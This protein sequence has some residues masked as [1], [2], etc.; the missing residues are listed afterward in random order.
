MSNATQQRGIPTARNVDHTAFTVPDLDE[1]IDFFV[2]VLG[3]ELLYHFGPVGD[4]S[5]DFMS[6]QLNV[7]PK[8]TCR[9]AMLR[10]GPVTN[11]ELFEYD[12]PNQ[13][14]EVPRNSDWGGHHLA[15][16]VDDIE[17][18]IA[19]L[20]E[21]PGV[22][23]LGEPQLIEEGPIAG[24]RWIYVLTPWGLQMEI[25]NQPPGAPYEK[26]TAARRFGPATAWDAR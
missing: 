19:Y 21:Q 25:M 7:D 3:A 20:R 12:A 22:T 18:A 13:R 6:R 10:F 2:E 11:I 1:A 26:E 4:P 8:A 24:N 14:R 5:G 16:F 23:I 17:A 15:I 9:F